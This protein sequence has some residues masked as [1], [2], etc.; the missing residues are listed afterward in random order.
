[1]PLGRLLDFFAKKYSP[2]ERESFEFLRAGKLFTELTN[3]ELVR[4]LPFLH[5]RKYTQN[6]A[7]FFRNDPSQALY[8]IRSGEIRLTI[9]VQDNFEELITIHQ[10][11]S[12]GDDALLPNSFRNYNAICTSESADLYVIPQI[13]IF[14]IFEEDP[15]IQAKV[16][17]AF[18]RYYDNYLSAI[19]KVYRES[20][21][22]FDLGQAYIQ[23][24]KETSIR[25]N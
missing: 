3:E 16:M 13:N 4:F 6:E 14:D 1:M 9:D 18:A 24:Q 23:A 19:F 10:K 25:N 11:M 21:G 22:F 17:T 2:H 20:F 15:R 12:F 8:I 5:E 7:V